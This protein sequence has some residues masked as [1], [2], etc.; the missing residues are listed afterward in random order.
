MLQQ[1]HPVRGKKMPLPPMLTA[2]LL[3]LAVSL[4]SLSWLPLP[5]AALLSLFDTAATK[6]KMSR[7]GLPLAGRRIFT[8]RCRALGSLGY[9]LGYHLLR[10]YLLPQLLAAVLY[11]PAG[12]L[13]ATIFLGVGLVDYRVRKPKMALVGFYLFYFLEQLAYG[14]GAFWGC[15]RT[16]SF[17]SYRLD[18]SKA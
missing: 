5:V 7:Q 6:R 1:L 3:L 18:L 13:V 14:S 15:F 2:I 16:R 4:L 9:Y 12:L 17:A 10:Y 11:P 8:A